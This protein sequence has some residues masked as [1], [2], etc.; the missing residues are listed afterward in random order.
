MSYHW[1]WAVFLQTS[2]GVHTY[3]SWLLQAMLTT[4]EISALAWV[5]AF[6]LGS[7]LGVMRTVP[8][9]TCRVIGAVYVDVLRNIPLIVQ[10]FIWYYLMPNL[11][12]ASWKN[13]LF[14]LP[15]EMSALVTAAIGLGV[16]TA[17]R[18]CE[19]VRGGIGSLPKGLRNAGLAMGLTLP[20]TYRY[21]VLPVAYR[22]LLPTLTSEL[23]ALV[24]NSS[25]A[26][27]VGVLELFAR[28]N[29]LNDY[30]NQP[31]ESFIAVCLCYFVI[32]TVVMLLMG[33]I[34]RRTRL[35]GF[36]TS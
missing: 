32:N 1:N 30:T 28:V 23:T 25:I 15:P 6:I 16:Y 14:S 24:K 21:V 10:L 2:D 3:L 11:L 34:E 7:V 5:I 17:S 26:S 20:Q 27:T 4:I 13:W 36:M 35:H 19:Q 33:W 12:P 9:R 18:I 31:Y 8:S 22:I 29:Q